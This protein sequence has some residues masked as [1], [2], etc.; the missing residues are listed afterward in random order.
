MPSGAHSA[1]TAVIGCG[2]PRCEQQLDRVDQ[3]PAGGEHRVDDDHRPAGERLGQ[4]V[5]VG[6]G[7]ER[8]LVAADPDEPDVGVGQQLLGGVHE[9]EPGAQDRHDHR[10]HGEPPGRRLGQ[11]RGH[12]R[13]DRRQVLRRPHQQQAADAL[14]VL[15]EQGVRRRD[16]ADPGKRVGDHR[17]L[18][19]GHG[20]VT[21]P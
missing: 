12:R 9:P 20:D 17:V 5:D 1:H 2:A 14:E 8:L 13:V 11:R 18:D 15:A 19:D 6:L 10:L 4:L 7:S 16:V 21:R 3:R